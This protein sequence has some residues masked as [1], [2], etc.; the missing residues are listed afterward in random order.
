MSF[1]D[2]GLT[3]C[4]AG[5]PLGLSLRWRKQ[6]PS[7]LVLGWCTGKPIGK[8][9]FFGGAKE[10]EE[11]SP[12]QMEPRHFLSELDMPLADLEQLFQDT[13]SSQAWDFGFCSLAV[14]R[15]WGTGQI[16]NQNPVLR[17]LPWYS[18]ALC[19]QTIGWG[20]A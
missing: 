5:K 12:T 8:Q 2:C 14:G 13:I 15:T 18:L 4:S 17:T 20:P 3:F 9:L 10:F 11:P 1:R 16:P 19:L 6:Q 7:L